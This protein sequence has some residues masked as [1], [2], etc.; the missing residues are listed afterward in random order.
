MERPGRG[1]G[2]VLAGVLALAALSVTAP[3]LGILLLI[4]GLP[5]VLAS[6]D[7][8]GALGC[9]YAA[10]LTVGLLVAAGVA[11]FLTCSLFMRRD[12]YGDGGLLPALAVALALLVG[13]IVAGFRILRRRTNRLVEREE[14]G[15]IRDVF[16]R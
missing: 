4:C 2:P 9:L 1:K 16:D 14:R 15:W 12:S 10:L 11:F 8:G 5:L 6:G 7:R 13:G 3:G